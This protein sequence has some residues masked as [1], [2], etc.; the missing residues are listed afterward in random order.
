VQYGLK[1]ILVGTQN[2]SEKRIIINIILKI[3]YGITL[4]PAFAKF[5]ITA[6]AYTIAIMTNIIMLILVL[7]YIYVINANIIVLKAE[8]MRYA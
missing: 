1:W 3:L 6:L 7:T 2:R 4:K 5:V 8:K